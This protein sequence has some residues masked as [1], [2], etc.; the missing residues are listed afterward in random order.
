MTRSRINLENSIESRPSLQQERWGRV[1]APPAPPVRFRTLK[2]AAAEM[3]GTRLA[4]A[5]VGLA[6]GKCGVPFRGTRIRTEGPLSFA[7]P[8]LLTGKY[9]RAEIDFIAR[10]LPRDLDVLEVGSSIGAT[11]C[12]IARRLAS[13]CRLTCVEANPTLIPVLR[14]NLASNVP[15][16]PIEVVHAVVGAAPGTAYFIPR[17]NSLSSLAAD[18]TEGALELRCESLSGLVSEHCPGD[19]SLVSD[20]EGAEAAFLA[21][22]TALRR[23]RFMVIEAHATIHQGNRLSIEDVIEMPLQAGRWRIKDRYGP[24][25]AYE[26][27]GE[28][29]S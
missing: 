26:R 18:N 23:C 14:R 17:L 10:Y 7:G 5:A 8:L 11:S 15:D 27:C 16:R 9:E 28:S 1:V 6:F 12:Q 21:D 2:L 25:V 29:L 4:R 22:D 24:V 3:L 19:F 13:G 20:V